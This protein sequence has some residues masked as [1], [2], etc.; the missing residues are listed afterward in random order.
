MKKVLGVFVV[1]SIII[2]LLAGL[3][4]SSINASD[5]DPIVQ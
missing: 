3:A 4:I 5:T 1:I 2:S